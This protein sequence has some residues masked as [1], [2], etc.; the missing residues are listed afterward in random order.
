MITLTFLIA[1]FAFATGAKASGWY[2]APEG[3]YERKKYLLEMLVFCIF[4]VPAL[5]YILL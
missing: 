3:T 5:I 4:L 2:N 1:F